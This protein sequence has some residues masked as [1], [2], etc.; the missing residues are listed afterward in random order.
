MKIVD[1]VY[2]DSGYLHNTKIVSD[3][4]LL[5]ITS[6]DINQIK[7]IKHQINFIHGLLLIKDELKREVKSDDKLDAFVGYNE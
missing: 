2:C 3:L 6:K 7:A 5:T 4:L 1:D